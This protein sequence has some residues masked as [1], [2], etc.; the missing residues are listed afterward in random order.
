MGKRLWLPDRQHAEKY[1]GAQGEMVERHNR[2]GYL[3]LPVLEFLWGQPWDD[4]ALSCVMTLRPSS[5][6][7][8]AGECTSDACCWRV[9][10]Y[11]NRDQST[12]GS[13]DQEMEIPI[14]DVA[15]TNGAYISGA[16]LER[17]IDIYKHFK[18]GDD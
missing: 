4:L 6:R 5:I 2:F 17:G 9:T 1:Y 7:V 15:R 10:V 11:L 18:E 3:S 8:T 14:Y 12:I 13:I 16:L